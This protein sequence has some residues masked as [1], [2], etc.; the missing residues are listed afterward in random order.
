MKA[1]QLLKGIGLCKAL[2]THHFNFAAFLAKRNGAGGGAL[3]EGAVSPSQENKCI[4]IGCFV[5]VTFSL[6][7]C[8]MLVCVSLGIVPYQVMLR[9]HRCCLHIFA[10][11]ASCKL[12]KTPK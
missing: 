1:L 4:G 12:R 2:G 3:G 8:V 5:G 6:F 9:Y 7:C 10:K 11:A